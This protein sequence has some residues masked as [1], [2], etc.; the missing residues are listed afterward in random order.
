MAVL[1]VPRVKPHCSI[2]EA[3][4]IQ[5]SAMEKESGDRRDQGPIKQLSFAEQSIRDGWEFFALVLVPRTPSNPAPV[6]C[7]DSFNSV[8]QDVLGSTLPQ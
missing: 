7:H 4:S 1:L 5:K 3:I 6:H 8:Q 2:P